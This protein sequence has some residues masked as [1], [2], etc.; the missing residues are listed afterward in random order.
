MTPGVGFRNTQLITSGQTLQ[1]TPVVLVQLIQAA[2]EQSTCSIQ[3]RIE[4]IYEGILPRLV[5]FFFSLLLLGLLE[6]GQIL[7][8]TGQVGKL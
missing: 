8:E 4:E 1:L 5:R 6:T 2:R 3:G 7:E